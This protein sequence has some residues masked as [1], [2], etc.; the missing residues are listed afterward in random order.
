MQRKALEGLPPTFSY[1]QA[2]QLGLSDYRLYALRD[3]GLVE[4]LGRG[5]YRRAD[6]A[7]TE[8]DL[9]EIAHRAPEAT[10]CLT[11][12]LAQHD[13]TDLIPSSIDIALPRGRRRPHVQ[14]PVTWHAFAAASFEIDRDQLRLDDQISIGITDRPAASSMLSGWPP[15]R[16]R[17]GYHRVTPMAAPPRR[18]AVHPIADGAG[19]PLRRTSHPSGVGSP[20]VNGTRPTRSSSAGSAYLNLRKLARGSGRPTDELHQLYAL[21]GFPARLAQSPYADQLILKGG[22]LLAAYNARR[23]TRDIDFHARRLPGDGDTVLELVRRVARLPANDGLTFDVDGA[24]A[25]TIRDEEPYAG[26]RVTMTAQ[27][28]TAR[29]RFHVDINV[30]DPVILSHSRSSCYSCWVGRSSFRLSAAD[31]A[32]REDRDRGSTWQRTHD[33]ATTLISISSPTVTR[34]TQISSLRRS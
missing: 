1:S 3:A 25:E 19:I 26:V 18:T 15:G 13:L 27:L 2:R 32:R 33:G 7:P 17:P 34:W 11:S 5:L 21:E 30:G 14:A 16:I 4:V 24:I 28:A 23:P 6:A 8:L 10:L 20:V 9:V 12:A 31:G 22:V 29:L